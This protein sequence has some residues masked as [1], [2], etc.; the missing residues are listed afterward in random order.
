MPRR[1]KAWLPTFPIGIRSVTCFA[2]EP[3]YRA[4]PGR[5]V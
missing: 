1:A 3:S 2:L 4:V 5:F